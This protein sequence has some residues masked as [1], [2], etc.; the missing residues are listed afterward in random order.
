MDGKKA[1]KALLVHWAHNDYFQQ[2]YPKEFRWMLV[3]FYATLKKCIQKQELFIIFQMEIF[4]FYL[5]EKDSL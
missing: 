1:F 5:Q 2:I 3:R 4:S